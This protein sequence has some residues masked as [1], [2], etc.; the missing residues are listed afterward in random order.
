MIRYC[1]QVLCLI[2]LVLSTKFCDIQAVFERIDQ[3]FNQVAASGGKYCKS[4]MQRCQYLPIVQKF[5][6]FKSV[7][8]LQL[9]LSL[10][11][12][13]LSVSGRLKQFN[14]ENTFKA[15]KYGALPA[16]YLSI[17]F[18]W[19]R[20]NLPGQLQLGAGGWTIN[21]SQGKD[22]DDP[23]C[24]EVQKKCRRPYI[25]IQILYNPRSQVIPDNPRCQMVMI[26]LVALGWTINPSQGKEQAARWI[27]C[28]HPF[29][30][31]D[32]TMRVAN[33]QKIR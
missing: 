4:G 8:I 7:W 28:L 31:H 23:R 11:L 22:H 10:P 12:S 13:N 30:T 1:P 20:V 16:H 32:R 27:L 26:Q 19:P 24:L 9:F 29:H 21:P 15:A 6:K 5:Y 14:Q 3:S 18:C 17:S 25:E 33:V 2:T